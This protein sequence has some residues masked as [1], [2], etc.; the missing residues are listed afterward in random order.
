MPG[1]P[2]PPRPPKLPRTPRHLRPSRCPVPERAAWPE[3]ILE[4]QVAA[5]R[6][7]HNGDV[8]PRRA[9]WSHLAPVTLFGAIV[10]AVGWS[11]VSSEFDSLAR[12]FTNGTSYELEVV[13]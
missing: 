1:S 5:E 2:S 11:D 4:R 9:M 13:A 3:P 10:D 8:G 7:F 6:A 12:R